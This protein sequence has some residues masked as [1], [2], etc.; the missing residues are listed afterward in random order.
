[1]IEID[2]A[3]SIACSSAH[4]NDDA[5]EEKKKVIEDR[6]SEVTK[7]LKKLKENAI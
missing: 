1:M 2:K 6:L 3:Y 4:N 5:L 7:K